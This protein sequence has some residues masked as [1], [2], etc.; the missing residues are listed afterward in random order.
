MNDPK[1]MVRSRGTTIL[2]TTGQEGNDQHCLPQQP[3]LPEENQYQQVGSSLLQPA[4][5]TVASTVFPIN[6]RFRSRGTILI[7]PRTG[8]RIFVWLPKMVKIFLK[9]ER[10]LS[11]F[12]I[13]RYPFNRWRGCGSL[14][15]L[16]P[17]PL[18]QTTLHCCLSRLW[19]FPTLFKS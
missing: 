7:R 9:R 14:H 3:P 10:N 12:R 19:Y 11:L 1:I 16:F 2:S 17:P 8:S 13:S 15:F 4:R 5:K 18:F 6:Q